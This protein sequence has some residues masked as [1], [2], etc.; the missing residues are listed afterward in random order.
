[1]RRLPHILLNTATVV[2]L[3]MCAATAVMWVRSYH[4]IDSFLYNVTPR[5]QL[6]VQAEHGYLFLSDTRLHPPVGSTVMFA[7]DGGFS[8]TPPVPWEDRSPD[9]VLGFGRQ[10]VSWRDGNFT[11]I[12]IPLAWALVACLL[13][14]A[15]WV[16][17]QAR[18]RK[19]AGLC[20]ACGYDLRATPDR[21]PEC[22]AV[23][24]AKDARLP[25][26]EG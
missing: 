21:C 16:V 10:A 8:T 12:R 22:G 14:P 11:S 3:V 4:A 20:P 9:A 7:S 5:Q 18:R 19:G 26:P 1:M 24:N 23:P 25:K 13:A 15:V 2:S 17:R 6:G